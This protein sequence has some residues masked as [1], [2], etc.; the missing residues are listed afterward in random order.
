LEYGHYQE[1]GTFTAIVSSDRDKISKGKLM[2]RPLRVE[3]PGAFY[4]VFSRGNN[5][6]DISDISAAVKAKGSNLTP[7]LH[8]QHGKG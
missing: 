3:Y 8:K 7:V 4:H 6:Q 2:A 1:S 5:Q